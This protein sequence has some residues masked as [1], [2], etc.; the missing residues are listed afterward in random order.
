MQ[1]PFQMGLERI[2]CSEW[3]LTHDPAGG[4]SGMSWTTA[5]A[6]HADFV[7]KH[8][9]LS[10]SPESG[11]VRVA[12]AERRDATGVD[13]IRGLVL[14]RVGT[15]AFTAEP[16]TRKR[17]WFD[18][19]AS[20]FGLHFGRAH[21]AHATSCG[22]R[23]SPPTDS[24]K[25]PATSEVRLVRTWQRRVGCVPDP[26][27]RTVSCRPDARPATGRVRCGSRPGR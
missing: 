27:G 24:G 25:K 19:L 21:P 23:S 18:L 17:E 12:M 3:H 20:V 15:N 9:W 11:F 4:F 10:T 2:G 5:P 16:L 13:V 14:A 8:A 6:R 26:P 7:E 1:G 22:T